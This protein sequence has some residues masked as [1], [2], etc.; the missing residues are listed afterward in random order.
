MKQ[1]TLL[2]AQLFCA[3]CAYAQ[4]DIEWQGNYGG[5]AAEEISSV[6]GT[7]D[8]GVLVG[9]FSA[10]GIGGNKT[11]PS[12][13][14]NDYWIIKYDEFGNEQ[15]QKTYGGSA[16]DYLYSLIETDDGGYLLA[17]SSLSGA[18]G[19]KTEASMGV[20][21]IWLIKI[22]TLGNIIWQESIGGNNSD[23]LTNLAKTNDGGFIV[24]SNSL[25]NSSFDKTENAFGG[26]ADYWIF[27]INSSGVI[28]WQNTIGGFA[29]DI[30]T[31]AFVQADNTVIVAGYS[32]SSIGGDKTE[33]HSGAND[34][35]ILKLNSTGGIVWQNTIGG[36][37]ADQA[38]SIHPALDGGIIVGGY[39]GSGVSGDKNE[40]LIGI[41]DY[42]FLKLNSLG[43]IVWQN[44]IG[45]YL[46]DFMLDVVPN[47]IENKYLL[48]GYSY[49]GIGADKAEDG[50]GTT[51]YWLVETDLEGNVVN[52]ETIRASGWEFGYSADITTD[53]G[54][55]IGGKSSSG[56]GLDKTQ[57]N[58]GDYDYWLLKLSNCVPTTEVC[59]SMDDDCD[60]HID[61][62]TLLTFY[63]DADGDTYGDVSA[64]ISMC[65][66]IPGYVE[67][68][69]D[70]NDDNPDI[71]PGATEIC[72]DIDDNCNGLTDDGITISCTITASGPTTF[73]QG[74]SVILTAT[75]TGTSQQWKRNGVN[76]PGATSTLLSVNTTGLYT[77][78]AYSDCDTVTATEI[79]V[80]VNKNPKA[81][82][83]A[84]GPTSFCVGGSVTLTETPSAGC[85][86]QW[87]KGASVIAGATTN[88]YVATTP[89]NYKCRVTKTATGCFKNSNSILVTVTCK[90]GEAVIDDQS[91]TIY[92]NP[93]TQQIHISGTFTT[94]EQLSIFNT[95]GD[96]VMSIQN[97][98]GEAIDIAHL[99]SGAYAMHLL[100]NNQTFTKVF[101]KE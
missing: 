43:N 45:G 1:I 79:N 23:N 8:G 26:S 25:S 70:C 20:Y 82:V 99:P 24:V 76:L 63:A 55:I 64:P 12:F 16:N 80:L 49:S 65:D 17:G 62:G 14:L 73:C 32:S 75:H 57:A 29:T 22:D 9:G 19:V 2:F 10:T 94:F 30:P 4:I 72:N 78:T 40:T 3:C 88:V 31:S 81:I 77:C 18:S 93:A 83:S 71:H 13:G 98:Q 100:S 51:D 33:I 36:T 42:W 27:K 5:S 48:F 35:W 38:R 58:Y 67:D 7:S 11:A 54:Y 37:G 66:I 6:I 53:G 61:E 59:N 69:T 68:N 21:D 91:I 84:G 52:Q 39:S 60:G 89:G 15:W 50:D 44:T 87:Y 92:P 86:Y 41:Y 28:Q 90:E 95:A 74:G 46:E 85:T 56:I 47:P 96:K 34:M 97:Y 101:V